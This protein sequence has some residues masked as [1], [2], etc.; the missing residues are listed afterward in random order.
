MARVLL[1]LFLLTAAAPPQAGAAPAD[2]PPHPYCGSIEAPPFSDLT[3]VKRRP[4][5]PRSR[6]YKPKH[7]GIGFEALD[8]ESEACFVPDKSYRL[9]DD[10]IDAVLQRLAETVPPP[11]ENSKADWY[12]AISR[13]TG[14][15]LEAKGFE[16]FI[17]TDT[18]GDTL[19]AHYDYSGK[20]HYIFDC[21]TS[22]LI[23]LTVAEVLSLPASM[24]DI[25]LPGGDGHNYVRWQ[26]DAETAID[27][28]TNGRAQCTTPPDLPSY[29]GKNLSREQ[30]IA[31]VRMLRIPLWE[32]QGSFVRAIDG[33]REAMRSFPEYPSIYNDFAWLVATKDF[34]ER[35]NY[36]DEA[37]AAAKKAV[38]LNRIPEYLDTLACVYALAGDFEQAVAHQYEVLTGAPA[39]EAFAER[40]L[41]FKAIPPKN[42]TGEE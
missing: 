20:P 12:L 14:D 23:L 39:E 37:L 13:I 11:A 34:P 32:Q 30:T 15:V 22:S 41:L 29:E 19:T 2:P 18:L 40:A 31:L 38:S 3:E 33:H 36:K 10:V 7:H 42:C 16:L 6:S 21:D 26:V 5:A 17:P 8:L 28:D 25:T 35:A 9:L 4:C 24:V 27:W 1:I